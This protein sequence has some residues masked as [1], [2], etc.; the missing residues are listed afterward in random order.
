[1]S[2]EIPPRPTP[3]S[4]PVR[5][6]SGIEEEKF[7][8]LMPG[9]PIGEVTII[10]GDPKAGKSWITFSWASAV[11]NGKYDLLPGWTERN[12]GKVLIFSLENNSS[13]VIKPRLRH[14]GANMKNIG[15]IDTYVN[16]DE[17]NILSIEKTIAEV[18]PD[19]VIF[20]PISLYV[21]GSLDM[22]QA[23]KVRQPMQRLQ[24]L[25]AKYNCAVVV[26]RHL[27]KGNSSK[28]MYRGQ[29]SID[30][31]AAVRSAFIAVTNPSN[32]EERALHCQGGNIGKPIEPLG[33]VIQDTE[34]GVGVLKWTDSPPQFSLESALSYQ[35]MGQDNEYDKKDA[36]TRLRE[37]L[38]DGKVGSTEVELM[39]DLEGFSEYA[40]KKAKRELKVIAR[41]EKQG[42]KFDDPVKW[43]LHLS[44]T[45]GVDTVENHPLPSEKTYNYNNNNLLEGGEEEENHLLPSP[46]SIPS[47]SSGKGAKV[48]RKRSKP[49]TEGGEKVDIHLLPVSEE[50]KESYRDFSKEGGEGIKKRL[51]PQITLNGSTSSTP[52]TEAEELTSLELRGET[53]EDALDGLDTIT[54]EVY[55]ILD[56]LM[57][58]GYPFDRYLDGLMTMEVFTSDHLRD[59]CAVYQPVIDRAKN[60]NGASV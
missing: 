35:T 24:T 37:I 34:D 57:E 53:G 20:D 29:G 3:K 59:L 49:V 58:I 31:V 12:P 19:L 60:G 13:K 16:L 52:D 45:E 46:S 48:A 36:V 9:V 1:M 50:N 47:P 51:L 11:S 43:F 10:D 27:N 6:L 8:W 18:K 15:V 26:V 56:E 17:A 4:L 25:A 54:K 33:Y 30:F 23:N 28:A 40:L 5:W 41:P 22:N 39:F 38:K 44:P 14:L 42:D 21:G 2:T 55:E 32:Q 7:E